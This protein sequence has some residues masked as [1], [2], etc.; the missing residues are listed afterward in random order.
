MQYY[1]DQLFNDV[2]DSLGWFV[3][4]PNGD[5]FSSHVS[6]TEAHSA[7][8]S[9]NRGEAV[10]APVAGEVHVTYQ[11][12]DAD[13]CIGSASFDAYGNFIPG[14]YRKAASLDAKSPKPPI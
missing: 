7:V 5:I 2:G 13:E 8:S 10:P 9:L 14:T 12:F 4:H 1:V 11:L 3:F 6:D